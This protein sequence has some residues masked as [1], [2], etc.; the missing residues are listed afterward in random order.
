[1]NMANKFL[2]IGALLAFL[3]VALGAFGAHGLKAILSSKMLVVFET[4]VRYHMY[5]A[6]GV[7][8]AGWASA[9]WKHRFFRYAA[10]A[11]I[12]GIVFFSGSLYVL[13]LTEIRW[14]GA[15]T[16]LG[17]VLFL[18]GWLLLAMGF[19]KGSTSPP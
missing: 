15:I 17:G 18:S 8:V 14:L 3:A 13:S 19:Y 7:I 5:H 2:M 9:T 16:P 12:L 11:F 1:M 4:G 6:F 10:W